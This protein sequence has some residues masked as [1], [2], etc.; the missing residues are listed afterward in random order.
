MSN[1]FKSLLPK[2]FSTIGYLISYIGVFFY[3]LSTVFLSVSATLHK[4]FG[5][6]VGLR[7]I[8][9]ENSTNAIIKF[10]T[11]AVKGGPNANGDSEANKLASIAKA[12]NVV[13][14]GK[15]KDD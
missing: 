8:E 4:L 13:Q 15:K 5:T 10:Y 7:L 1:F 12:N 14:L 9:I 6:K 2:T 3:G 11:D